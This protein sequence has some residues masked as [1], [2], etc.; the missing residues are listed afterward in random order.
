MTFEALQ[1]QY[2][3]SQ[4]TIAALTSEKIDLTAK[5]TSAL[6]EQERLKL[7]VKKLQ[8]KLFGKSSERRIGDGARQG[9]LFE[10][11]QQ[12]QQGEEGLEIA[13]H[14][15]RVRSRFE[16]EEEAGEGTFPEHLRR[17]DKIID[18]K[19]EGY[20]DDELEVISTKVT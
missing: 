7:L 3:Q 11:A 5:L 9:L 6:S 17:E 13:A 15:R 8:G 2:H 16:T 10:V 12:D 19:P 1:E 14:T 18:E 20:A 4:S